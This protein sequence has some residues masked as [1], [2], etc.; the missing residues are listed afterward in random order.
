M[1]AAT[2]QAGFTIIEVVIA[3]GLFLIGMSS[4]LGLLAFGAAL[5]RNA[6]LASDAAAAAEGVMAD[7][8][9]RLFPLVLVDGEWVAGEPLAIVDR[10]LPSHPGIV[11]S[12]TAVPDPA[13][14]SRSS[15]TLEYKV[16]VTLTWR[17]SGQRRT[18]TFT[19]LM[20]REV[21][22]GERLR[23]LFVESSPDP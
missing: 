9:E 10:P 13:G 19:T 16:D 23:R 7:L 6:A 22:F 1:R 15:D 5:T 2:R 8:E 12:A 14:V 3:M 17:N 18:R 21:P 4:V 20:L 11:Y